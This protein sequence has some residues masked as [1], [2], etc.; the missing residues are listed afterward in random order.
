[1]T[2]SK[3]DGRRFSK[4]SLHWFHVTGILIGNTISCSTI[5]MVKRENIN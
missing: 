4:D 2:Y 1:M 3:K 5:S